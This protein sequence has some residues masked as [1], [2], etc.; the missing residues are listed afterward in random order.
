MSQRSVEKLNNQQEVKDHEKNYK[1][2]IDGT[3]IQK[4]NNNIRL[5]IKLMCFNFRLICEVSSLIRIIKFFFIVNADYKVDNVDDVI[6]STEKSNTEL[7]KG[8]YNTIFIQD[9]PNYSGEIGQYKIVL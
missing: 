9:A 8:E 4:V 2:E 6:T 3:Y 5:F 1:D 7:A